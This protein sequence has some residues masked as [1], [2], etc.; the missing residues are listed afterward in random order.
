MEQE[1]MI[2]PGVEDATPR[3]LPNSHSFTRRPK[4]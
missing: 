1:I 3:V 2:E 4:S